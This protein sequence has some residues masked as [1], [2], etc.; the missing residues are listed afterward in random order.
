MVRS[1]QRRTIVKSRVMA[2]GQQMLRL[3]K[4]DCLPPS[5]EEIAALC[6]ALEVLMPQ[7]GVLVISDYAKG[8]LTPELRQHIQRIAQALPRMPEIL[9][10]PKPSNAPCYEHIS[11]MT[12]NKKEAAQLAGIELRTR[13][14]II[15]LLLKNCVMCTE[16]N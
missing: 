10:D 12:P 6:H 13:E 2:R 7:H 16:V 8:L 3:D 5:A 14:D 4:E 15:D 1:S 9:V 11:L